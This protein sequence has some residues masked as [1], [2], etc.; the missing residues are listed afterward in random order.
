IH[1]LR[2]LPAQSVWLCSGIGPFQL[3]LTT[4]A[5]FMGGHVR[6]GL[7]DNLYYARGR[8]FKDNAEAVRR[9]VRLAGE[10]NRKVA[11]PA[12]TR[13]LLGLPSNPKGGKT[14]RKPA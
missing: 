8:K 7:E 6:V 10:L 9:A 1:L 4:M 13:A 5:L 3:P 2:E 14:A 12:E 11:T